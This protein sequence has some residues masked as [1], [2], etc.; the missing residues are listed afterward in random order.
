[1]TPPMLRRTLLG[2]LAL[3]LTAAAGACKSGQPSGGSSGVTSSS[4]PGT[5]GAP[6]QALGRPTGRRDIITLEEIK[7]TSASTALDLIRQLRPSYLN[8]RGPQSLTNDQAGRV[9]VYVNGTR[10]GYVESLNEISAASVSE[11]RRISGVDATQRWGIGHAG[12]VIYV[13][14]AR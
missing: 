2:A 4:G 5:A 11:V 14:V 1:M 8:D 12:G 10:Y 13:T 6:D 9:I 7:K 3:A